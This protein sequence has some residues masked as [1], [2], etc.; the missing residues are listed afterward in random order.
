ML[1]AAGGE[2]RAKKTRLVSRVKSTPKEEGG[3][4]NLRVGCGAACVLPSRTVP[5]VQ[6]KSVRGK[7]YCATH[8]IVVDV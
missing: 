8:N 3:G 6:E 1:L 7:K 4:D 5:I 2:L